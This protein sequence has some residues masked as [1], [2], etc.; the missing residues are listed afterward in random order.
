MNGL[1]ESIG[2]G[3]SKQGYE[4]YKFKHSYTWK[5]NRRKV[6]AAEYY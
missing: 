6:A 3:N 1:T 2:S 4:N 5:L